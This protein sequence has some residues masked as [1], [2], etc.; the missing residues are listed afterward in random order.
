MLLRLERAAGNAARDAE[1][2]RLVNPFVEAVRG[3]ES[4]APDSDEE[5]D[6]GGIPLDG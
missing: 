4:S 3:F 2:M 1:R 5:P 6:C